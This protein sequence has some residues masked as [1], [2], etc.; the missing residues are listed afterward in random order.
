MFTYIY[1]RF[2]ID[3]QT[4]FETYEDVMLRASS[5]VEDNHAFPVKILDENN[6]EILTNLDNKESFYEAIFDFRN[7]NK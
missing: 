7:Q 4:K 2:G 6:N 3:G 1:T 5:D